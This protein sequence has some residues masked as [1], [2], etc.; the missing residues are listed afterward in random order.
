VAVLHRS[1]PSEAQAAALRIRSASEWLA[2]GDAHFVA[3]KVDGQ[4]DSAFAAYSTALLLEPSARA[5]VQLAFIDDV[6]VPRTRKRLEHLAQVLGT[7]A[8]LNRAMGRR[9]T[10]LNE[11]ARRSS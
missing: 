7:E 2:T 6:I 8:E 11:A 1:H 4:I 3:G 10:A 9:L 5:G